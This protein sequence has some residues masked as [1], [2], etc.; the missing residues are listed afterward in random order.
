MRTKERGVLV[1]RRGDVRLALRTTIFGNAAKNRELAGW[2]GTWLLYTIYA[3]YR[4]FYTLFQR[5]V[6]NEALKCPNLTSW[7]D[8]PNTAHGMFSTL[9]IHVHAAPPS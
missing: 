6:S 8:R 9:I 2:P 5:Y 3:P 1:V 7:S 4:I